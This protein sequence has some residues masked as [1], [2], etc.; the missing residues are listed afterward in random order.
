MLN[1]YWAYYEVKA[2]RSVLLAHIF[3]EEL[4]SYSNR[5][6]QFN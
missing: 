1:I 2:V 3:G 4:A 6:E 5:G